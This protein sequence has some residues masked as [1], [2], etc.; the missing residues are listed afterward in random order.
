MYWPVAI[1]LPSIGT[2]ILWVVLDKKWYR[3]DP[4]EQSMLST[5]RTLH[6]VPGMPY[7]LD[8]KF[9]AIRHA[10]VFLATA[11]II[12]WVN[13]KWVINFVLI[14]NLLYAWSTISRYRMRK[15]EVSEVAKRDGEQTVANMLA[16]PVRASFCVVVF[17]VLCAVFLYVL[18][19]L[20]P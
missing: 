3:L 19:F 6:S 13:A 2:A 9:S 12:Y 20:K 14:A 7:Y 15:S 10:V 17:S 16:I 1:M 5:L 8:I 18:M 4:L 11:A